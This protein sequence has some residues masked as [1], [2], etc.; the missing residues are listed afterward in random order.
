M[1]KAEL[2]QQRAA[3]SERVRQAN[4]LEYWAAGYRT[5][6][7]DTG[8]E[9]CLWS[10]RE[11]KDFMVESEKLIDINEAERRGLILLNPGLGGKPYMTNT[12]F[13]DVQLLAP[14]EKAPAHRHTTS[15]S[16]FFLEGHG[17]YTTVEGEKCTMGP[18]DLIINPSWAWHDHGHEGQSDISYLNILDVPLVASLGCVFYD[19]EYSK[20]GD[21]SKTI[22]SLK[23]PV[24][25]SHDLYATGGIVPRIVKRTNRPYS[26]QLIFRFADVMG[27][28][29]RISKFEPDPYDG[30]I[31]EYVNPENG[32]SVVPTMSFTMQMLT[33]GRRTLAHRHT[34]STVFCC[35]GGRGT[36][37]VEGTKLEWS[38]NDIF[39]V[40]TWAWHEHIN[41]SATEPAL[42]FA[43]SDA[44]AIQKLSLYREEGRTAAG[45]VISVAFP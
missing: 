39:A 4:Y 45:E 17:G 9:P 12:I 1:G 40:P 29:S 11:M 30:H 41:A 6:K 8:V 5:T 33:G 16:R 14:G 2:V 43:V 31:V 21:T 10:W 38:K 23:K 20:E 26:P 28:L 32:N 42:L 34:S 35:A 24:N 37:F 44:P 27:A 15:A 3:F 19:S 7:P 13:G 18:G 36:T 25:A 22:Q